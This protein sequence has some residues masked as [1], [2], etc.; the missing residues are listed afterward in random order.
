MELR[1]ALSLYEMPVSELAARA[2]RARRAS[3]D[4]GLELCGIV[5]AKSGRCG[6]DCHFCAQSARYQTGCPEYP[7]K[8]AR[9]I[10]EAARRAAKMGCGHFGI[11]TSG[12][13]LSDGELERIAEAVEALRGEFGLKV[14]ASLGRLGADQFRR[15]RDAGLER[16]NHNI[17]TSPRYFPQVVTTHTFEDRAATVRRAA[18]AGLSVCCG[19]IIGMG[20]TREDR[21]SLGL[22]LRE[23]PV[24][25]V[26]LNVLMSI[27]GT[28]LAVCRSISPIEVVKTV[29]VFRI[30]MPRRTIKLAAGREDA[31]GDFQGMAF[32]A[33]A[34]GMILGDYLTQPGPQIAKD[35]QLL[36]AV[37]E[38]WNPSLSNSFSSVAAE[39]PS[40]R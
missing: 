5:N 4:G 18:E 23:L 24:D 6:E 12:A 10:V 8:A 25:S 30:L 34:S 22:A 39:M 35:R 7:L 14:C 1:E 21:A 31:L 29:A 28:P 16:Y 9:Q 26:P 37:K 3:T 19:G 15:L 27:P 38:A 40:A 13:T 2:D 36:A 20:E 33:G 17:E 32:M 11:V